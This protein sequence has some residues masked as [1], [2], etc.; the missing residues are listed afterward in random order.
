MTEEK[1]VRDAF[2][3]EAAVRRRLEA[4]YGDQIQELSF[5][6][7]WYSTAGSKEFWDV[8][9]TLHLKKGKVKQ[10]NIRYQVDPI[11]GDIFG[12][13]ETPIRQK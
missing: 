7:M 9:A 8:E 11:T 4:Q 2:D 3:A 12:Y 6:K 1:K 13:Q 10:K 5:T